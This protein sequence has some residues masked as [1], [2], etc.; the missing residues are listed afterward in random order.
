MNTMSKKD[1]LEELKG[2]IDKCI[3]D[4]ATDDS[5]GELRDA[6]ATCLSDVPTTITLGQFKKLQDH[7][8]NRFNAFDETGNINYEK[9]QRNVAYAISSWYTNYNG[10]L[11]K[12][13]QKLAEISSEL[14]LAKATAYHDIKMTKAKYDI[15]AR[16]LGIMVDGH[17]ITRAKQLEF[18]KQQAYVDYLDN[19]VKQI[20]FYSNG[21]DKILRLQ[22]HT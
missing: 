5:L 22:E 9:L 7:I 6:T 10:L 4:G 17:E 13:K 11:L 16:G 19:A 12:E 20:G 2:H 1:R 8:N 3:G 21:V 18:D 15:D 14:K